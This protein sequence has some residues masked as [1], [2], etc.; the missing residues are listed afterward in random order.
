MKYGGAQVASRQMHNGTQ[1]RP[2]F[3]WTH[4]VLIRRGMPTQSRRAPSLALN[5]L[6]R[7]RCDNS[8]RVKALLCHQRIQETNA[9]LLLQAEP[10]ACVF[11]S[12]AAC[13]EAL[14]CRLCV[15]LLRLSCWSTLRGRPKGPS[16]KRLANAWSWAWLGFNWV[17]IF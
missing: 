13:F 6:V 5:A 10:S 16:G 7:V 12:R 1:L 14:T 4:R 3:S 8:C 9:C 17:P 11:A 2:S 15:S